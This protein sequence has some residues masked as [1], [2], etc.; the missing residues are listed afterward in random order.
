MALLKLTAYT[1]VGVFEGLVTAEPQSVKDCL[2]ARDRLEQRLA[3]LSYIVLRP[4]IQNLAHEIFLP[5]TLLQ[6]SVLVFN[7]VEDGAG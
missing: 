2:L 3:Q 6:S 7:I 4:D 5:G 1:T